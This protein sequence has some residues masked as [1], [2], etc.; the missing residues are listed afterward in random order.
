MVLLGAAAG[1][2]CGLLEAAWLIAG[3]A[4]YFDGA[5][6][7]ARLILVLASLGGAAGVAVGLAEEGVR[8]F[9]PRRPLTYTILMAPA[10][11]WLCS[12]VFDGPQ[13]RRIPHHG[14]LA[15][16]LGL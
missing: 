5:G 16:A 12:H 6:E 11:A 2:L 9:L 1:L 3:T 7:A 4:Q 10:I 15:V 13:A 8:R 14:A